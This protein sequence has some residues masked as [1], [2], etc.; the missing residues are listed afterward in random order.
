MTLFNR[1]S[2]VHSEAL[3]NREFITVRWNLFFYI[4]YLFASV[5]YFNFRE[6]FFV[7]IMKSKHVYCRKL[8]K[9]KRKRENNLKINSV[10]KNNHYFY[11][12]LNLFR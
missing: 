8:G 6:I 2:L 12:G 7:L 10:Q 3:T 9:Y 11:F 1:Q 4:G 5:C